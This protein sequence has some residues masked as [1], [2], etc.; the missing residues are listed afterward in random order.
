M[1]KVKLIVDT[2]YFKLYFVVK[3]RLLSYLKRYI[4]F[5]VVLLNANQQ[6]NIK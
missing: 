1:I 5:S 2:N 4:V 6:F 3:Q